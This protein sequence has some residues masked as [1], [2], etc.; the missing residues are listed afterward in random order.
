VIEVG[1]G[2]KLTVTEIAIVD[3][4]VKDIQDRSVVNDTRWDSVNGSEVEHRFLVELALDIGG[5]GHSSG[6]HLDVD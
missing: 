3:R 5:L 2:Q 1:Q 6:S 4:L